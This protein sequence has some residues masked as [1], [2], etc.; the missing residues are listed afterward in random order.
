MYLNHSGKFPPGDDL[1][2][3]RFLRMKGEFLSLSYFIFGFFRSM[4]S[5]PHYIVWGKR[6]RQLLAVNEKFSMLG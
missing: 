4:P 1:N 3:K 2:I 6:I 5:F